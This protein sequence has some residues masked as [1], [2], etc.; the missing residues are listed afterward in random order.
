MDEMKGSDGDPLVLQDPLVL[1]FILFFHL[2]I[3]LLLSIH[4]VSPS[5][6]YS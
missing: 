6:R 5:V 4:C 3:V 2:F 1:L